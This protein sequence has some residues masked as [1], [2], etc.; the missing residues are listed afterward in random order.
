MKISALLTVGLKAIAGLAVA[1]VRVL[2]QV[3]FM[4]G[5][6]MTGILVLLF[7]T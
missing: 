2:V 7:F 3:F 1:V 5:V 6:L 4:D